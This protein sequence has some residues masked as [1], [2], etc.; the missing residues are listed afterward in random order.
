MPKIP[1]V[2]PEVCVH[3]HSGKNYEI[4]IKLPGVKK[5]N[6]DL[7]FSRKGFSVKGTRAD[8]V[9][10]GSHSLEHSVDVNKIKTKHYDV[11]GL[12]EVIAPLVQPL[13]TKKIQVK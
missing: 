12:L 2:A 5:E 6:I 13:R 11:E 3:H 9:F 1:N 7:N 8:V 10:A 4:H